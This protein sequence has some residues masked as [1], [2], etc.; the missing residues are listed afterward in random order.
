MIGFVFSMLV[1][2]IGAVT[3]PRA[4]QCPSGF[5]VAGAHFDGSYECR[6]SQPE[7]GPRAPE[8]YLVG[9]LYCGAGERPVYR[10]GERVECRRCDG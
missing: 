4:A 3:R 5:E 6:L 9:R 2:A 10:A 1:L 8:L 7:R